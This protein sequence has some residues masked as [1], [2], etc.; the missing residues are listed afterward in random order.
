MLSFFDCRAV[1]AGHGEQGCEHEVFS[2]VKK[3]GELC[4]REGMGLAPAS[5]AWLYRQKGVAAVLTG[6]GNSHDLLKTRDPSRSICRPDR[7]MK[8][9]A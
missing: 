1:D 7:P 3:L 2:A 6:A 5:I 4:Q 9:A 8:W